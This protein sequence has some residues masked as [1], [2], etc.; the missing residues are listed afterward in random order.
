M[1]KILF[2]FLGV[3][4][5][6]LQSCFK[7]DNWDEPDGEIFGTVTDYYTKAPILS[8]QN[9]WQMRYWEKTWTGHE[10]GAYQHQDLRIKQDGTFQHTKLFPGT[11]DI[12]PY[13][14][15]YW[16]MDTIKGVVIKSKGK[17]ELNF[18]VIPYLQVVDF[19]YE[20]VSIGRVDPVPGLTFRCKVRAPILEKD[21]VPLPNL[22]WVK[23]FISRTIWCG[24]GEN[25]V[26]GEYLDV[27]ARR[28]P[29][30]P[31]DFVLNNQIPGTTAPMTT[32]PGNGVDT[33]GE[34]VIGPLLVKSGYTYWVRMGAAVDDTYRN[35]SYS[36]IQKVVIP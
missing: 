21:G 18:E 15:P 5:M 17:T 36:E 12:L 13:N 14:G 9:G 27:D 34:F 31:W 4:L 16:P 19:S 23:A 26:I 30:R 11:Y 6:S 7:I 2:L 3:A 20:I 25:S 32:G 10:G 28:Q 8:T 29:N 24:Q 1:K 35:Y 33:T 22:F